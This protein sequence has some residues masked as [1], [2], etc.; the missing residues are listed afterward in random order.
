[1]NT[2]RPVTEGCIIEP[3]QSRGVGDQVSVVVAGQLPA[4]G[5]S[6]K[7]RKSVDG[8]GGDRV[9][10][11]RQG[12]VQSSAVSGGR[13]LNTII[14]ERK[15]TGP[16]RGVEGRIGA[17]EDDVTHDSRPPGRLGRIEEINIVETA[18]GRIRDNDS[19]VSHEVGCGVAVPFFRRCDM[20]WDETASEWN[21]LWRAL[22][23]TY[24]YSQVHL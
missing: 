8:R 9:V 23:T 5:D 19:I 4:N 21:A 17:D 2:A 12:K 24:L 16:T 6:A 13:K 22:A 15:G 10:V 3:A 14:N 11:A 7:V 20:Y 1:M 18:T